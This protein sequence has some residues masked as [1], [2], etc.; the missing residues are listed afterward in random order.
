MPGLP[1]AHFQNVGLPYVSSARLVRDGPVAESSTTLEHADLFL[2]LNEALC[3]ALTKFDT[4]EA[5]FSAGRS[6]KDITDILLEELLG[7]AELL[8]FLTGSESQDALGKHVRTHVGRAYGEWKKMGNAA[9][10]M[11]KDAAKRRDLPLPWASIDA[12]PDWVMNQ[13]ELHMNADPEEVDEAR[14]YLENALLAKP[15]I[16]GSIKYDGTCFGK[17][18]DEEFCGRKDVLGRLCSEY[19]RTSTAS[20]Q[21]CD[22]R[23]FKSLLSEILGV[24]VVQAC[25]WGEL[26]C[27][28]NFYGYKAR[29]LADKWVCFGAVATFDKA[30]ASI[31]VKLAAHG[32]AHSLN[33]EGTKARLMTCPA[34]QELLRRAGA[35]DVAQDLF[36]GL[37][38][39]EVVAKGRAELQNGENEGI[40]IV[41]EGSKG[42]AS[43]RKWKNSSEGAS[44]RKKEAEAL[45]ECYRKCKD[46]CDEGKL[47]MR[48]AE[49]VATLQSVAAAE[50]NPL[51]KGRD[52]TQKKGSYGDGR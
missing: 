45:Q 42:Q 41:F 22:V 50:T 47:D 44:A 37:T 18:D 23:Q 5:Q 10:G 17:L 26:M 30:D 29:G 9:A 12:Y 46:L 4:L 34:L 48:I 33:K 36:Q 49:M 13:I 11:S 20:T 14:K 52:K 51:K 2:A 21:S 6:V 43:L 28:P 35:A 7:D 39:A 16:S 19:Q 8:P 3:S 40:I 32:L 27:N 25:V 24:S 38:H 15:I 1:L 31:P